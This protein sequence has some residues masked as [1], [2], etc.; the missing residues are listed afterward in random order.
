LNNIKSKYILTELD[1]V[2]EDVGWSEEED[3]DINGV[4]LTIKPFKL[5][6]YL[7][8]YSLEELKKFL[9]KDIRMS[10]KILT[11][12]GLGSLLRRLKINFTPTSRRDKSGGGYASLFGIVDVYP[13]TY[14]KDK[15]FI[16]TLFHEY[17]HLYWYRILSRVEIRSWVDF[18]RGSTDILTEEEINE[19]RSL[20]DK[21]WDKA[22]SLYSDTPSIPADS[23]CAQMMY[24]TSELSATTASKVSFYLQS[25]RDIE[26]FPF[27]LMMRKEQK[28]TAI[29]NFIREVKKFKFWKYNISWYA[30]T[31]PGEAWSEVF[32]KYC[33]NSDIPPEVRRNFRILCG[34]SSGK[35]TKDSKSESHVL[36]SNALSVL[37][38]KI[39]YHSKWLTSSG[40]ADI[41]GMHPVSGPKS[42]P[43]L[44]SD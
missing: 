27:Y 13:S 26:E 28:Q 15:S 4:T 31:N 20:L 25:I 22:E 10:I 35:Q 34:L 21:S 2:L 38:K 1:S 3:I 41:Y 14:L 8:G 6:S 33:M 40:R 18:I 37:I 23:I 11:N 24:L 17:G 29:D 44:Y 30:N 32:Q 39:K 42:R 19:I 9:I 12:K 7:G 43:S 36:L 5:N 16:P